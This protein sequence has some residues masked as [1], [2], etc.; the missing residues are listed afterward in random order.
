MK[1]RLPEGGWELPRVLLNF[2]KRSLLSAGIRAFSERFL[3][4]CLRIQKFRSRRPDLSANPA[5]RPL[6]LIRKDK[7]SVIRFRGDASDGDDHG[8]EGDFGKEICCAAERRGTRAT[9][10]ADTQRQE[11]SPTLS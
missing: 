4:P 3:A 9:R 11:R 7:G 6:Q 10:S 2:V 1:S 5:S 8:C